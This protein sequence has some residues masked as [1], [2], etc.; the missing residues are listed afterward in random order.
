M[1]IFTMED[2]NHVLGKPLAEAKA[3]ALSA[4]ADRS[5]NVKAM[6]VTKAKQMILKCRDSKAI[7]FGM[8]GWI[9]A[10]PTEGLKVVKVLAAGT[11]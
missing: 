8:S 7:A 6:T 11:V 3:Y 5:E 4:I 2:V 10:H 9:L 1:S